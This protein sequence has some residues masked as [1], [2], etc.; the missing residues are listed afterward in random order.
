ME[1]TARQNGEQTMKLDVSGSQLSSMTNLGQISSASHAKL[2]PLHPISSRINPQA[3]Q[4]DPEKFL[5]G[6]LRIN[7][8]MDLSGLGN[9]M[10][11]K[12]RWR[13]RT[14]GSRRGK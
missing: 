2:P 11:A 9:S 7:T 10:Q 14:L 12:K 1:G 6:K 4:D 8:E 3:H 13:P 5:V